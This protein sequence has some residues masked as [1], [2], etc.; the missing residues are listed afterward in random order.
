MESTYLYARNSFKQ[1][2]YFPSISVEAGAGS[3]FHKRCEHFH[4]GR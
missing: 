3:D 2:K 1:Q 4:K